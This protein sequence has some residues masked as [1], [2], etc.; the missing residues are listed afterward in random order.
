MG[1]LGIRNTTPHALAAYT[2]SFDGCRTL[3]TTILPNG[4]DTA[5]YDSC[6]DQINSALPDESKIS[7]SNT[8]QHDTSVAIEKEAL[9]SHIIK[10][11]YFT[12]AP[13]ALAILK[14]N[15]AKHAGAF[16]TAPPIEAY[17]LRMSKCEFRIALQ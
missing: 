15:Q 16:L 12:T 10:L 7:P 4:L 8:C 13:R 9:K 6:I 2:A 14:C 5:L 1:G 3:L 17:G 11:G